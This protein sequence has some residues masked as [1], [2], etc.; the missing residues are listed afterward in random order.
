MSAR[1]VAL[2][3]VRDVFN[4]EPAQRRTAQESLNYHLRKGQLEARDRGFATEVSYGAIKMRRLTQWYLHPYTG[5][6]DKALPPVINEILHL[7]VYELLFMRSP[8]H[9]VVSEYVGLAKMFGHRGT[10]GLVNAVLRGF[11]RDKPP[12]PEAHAF[13]DPDD[14]LATKH[15]FPTWIVKQWRERFGEEHLEAMLEGVNAPARAAV[16]V[17]TVR[18]DVESVESTFAAHGVP[19]TRSRFVGD[20]LLLESGAYAQAH[21][22]QAAGAW[23][24]HS[25]S[26]AMPVDIMNPQPGEAVLDLCSGRGNK[27]LQEGSRLG[28]DGG[29]T[30]VEKDSRKAAALELR[31]RAAGIPAAVIVGDATQP[32]VSEQFDRVILDAPCSGTG[33][34]GRHPEARWRKSAQDGARLA[35]LQRALLEQAAIHL[36]PG[37]VL[38]YAV[39]STDPRESDEVVS[40]FVERNNF[41]RGLV[42]ER[43]EELLTPLGDVVVLPGIEGRD[44]FYIA[45]LERGA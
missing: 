45:R 28:G 19:T 5:Q 27:A 33:T 30:C 41:T 2:A 7:A 10:A 32:V 23:V 31:L 16:S 36:H 39:C 14:Y 40:A 26:A 3:V 34:L 8:E 1:K 42:P 12:A 24:V 25:E 15:S 20:T 22:A 4:L 17:N 11:L 43:Y 13:S 38:I 37:G 29:L 18:T 6:R 9:A 35:E 21:E 44:G